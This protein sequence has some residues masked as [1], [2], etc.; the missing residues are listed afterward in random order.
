MFW[1]VAYFCVVLA[2]AVPLG[3]FDG[4]GNMSWQWVGPVATVVAV[5]LC[6]ASGPASY[7]VARRR[8]FLGSSLLGAAAA[9]VIVVALT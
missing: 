7:A 1:G 4:P 9:L 8:F 5:V 6:L 3:N 2:V